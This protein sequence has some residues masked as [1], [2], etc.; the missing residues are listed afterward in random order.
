MADTFWVTRLRW[1]AA[2]AAKL[3]GKHHLD[4]DDV[5]AEVE[6]RR[7]LVGS[8]GFREDVGQWRLET[9]VR[10]R[11]QRVLVVLKEHPGQDDEDVLLSAF[12]V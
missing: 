2:T 12:R 10:V 11:G 4:L 9:Y 1:S 8:W 6:C 3:A 5:R 7:G